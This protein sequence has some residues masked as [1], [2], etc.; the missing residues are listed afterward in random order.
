MKAAL[1][2]LALGVAFAGAAAAQQQMPNVLFK[3]VINAS[4]PFGYDE[5]TTVVCRGIPTCTGE[6]RSHVR[7]E[8]CAGYMDQS[9]SVVFT[10][11]DLT[12]SGTFQGQL[13]TTSPDVARGPNGACSFT[14]QILTET[15]VYTGTWDLA[16]QRGAIHAVF[17]PND[18]VNIG[19]TADLLAPAEIFAMVVR[20]R[21]G[22]QTA[23]VSADI[24]F[25]AQDIGR[26]A[27]VFVFASAPAGRVRGG[28]EAKAV[29]LG[30]ARSFA[31][32]DPPPPCVLAQV[33]PTGQLVAVSAAQLQAYS[34]GVLSAQ[35]QSVTILDNTP[36]SEVAGATFYVGYGANGTD[37]ISNSVF[38]N[39]AVI[40]GSSVCPM[41]PYQTALYWN[42]AESGWGINVNQQ[43]SIAF[44]TL[45]TYDAARVPTWLVMSGGL[46]QPDGL[47]FK[48]E[49]YR[50]TGPAFNANPFTPIGASNLTAVGSMTLA[51]SDANTATLTYTFNG[52]TVEKNIQRQVY[53]TRSANCLPT[54]ES[55]AG[56]SNYQD[57]WWNPAESGWGMNITH[58]DNTLF[59]TLFTYEPSGRDLWLV[60]SGGVRQADGSYLGTLYKTTGSPFDTLP[61]PPIGAGDLTAV[62]TMRLRFANGD[63]GTLTY[64]YNGATV[65]KAISRQVFS[66]PQAAC[67]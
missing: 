17:G 52:T 44:A 63:N 42:P 47:S 60:M 64:T 24:N 50:T 22:A 66:V 7:Q 54:V 16:T 19:F 61:F 59:A 13:T 35:G 4:G 25:R 39:T 43:G 11:L 65:T 48:G 62:G 53:G 21:I 55:R 33:S 51:F 5:Q 9:G 29:K 40:P 31:K 8:N 23:T 34:T 2:A 38:R 67:N 49:L 28:L 58:Q 12:R 20:S 30:Y 18:V 41:L 37:M 3:G 15:A 32:A 56:Q 46:L 1:A 6:Y 45:F 36:V 14:G 26:N 27:G 57:L 10:G